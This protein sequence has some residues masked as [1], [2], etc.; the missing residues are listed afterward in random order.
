MLGFASA[1]VALHRRASRS[2]RASL[3]WVTSV[4][5]PQSD[6][7]K[8][9]SLSGSR[10]PN[11][12]SFYITSF[13]LATHRCQF[14][15]FFFPKNMQ[16]MFGFYKTATQKGHLLLKY[17][18]ANPDSCY[19]R[20]VIYQRD[21]LFCICCDFFLLRDFSHRSTKKQIKYNRAKR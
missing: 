16:G 10:R 1:F 7:V 8:F 3:L 11:L 18:P 15:Y 14:I 21:N 19:E 5:P 6:S 9:A 12:N 17:F 4:L 2:S 20:I 13:P